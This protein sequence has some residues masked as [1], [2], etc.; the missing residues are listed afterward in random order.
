MPEWKSIFI[1]NP[2]KTSLI[3]L[4]TEQQQNTLDTSQTDITW[5]QDKSEILNYTAQRFINSSI[6]NILFQSLLAENAARFLAMDSSTTNA[7]NFLEKLTLQ[8][9]KSRQALITREV[10]E[11]SANL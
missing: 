7:E 10:S 11:L 9:N 5:E 2:Q 1:Q 3:S 4:N 8:Y 6:L